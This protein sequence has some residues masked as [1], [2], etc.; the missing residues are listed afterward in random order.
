MAVIVK[1]QT[2][3]LAVEKVKVRKKDK[4]GKNVLLKETKPKQMLELRKDERKC[5][6]NSE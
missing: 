3:S 2:S 4:D 6:F 1:P 5:C